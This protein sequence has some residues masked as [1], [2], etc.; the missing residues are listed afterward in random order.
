VV[1]SDRAKLLVVGASFLAA[2]VVSTLLIMK[3]RIADDENPIRVRNKILQFES[4][5]PNSEWSQDG[6]KWRLKKNKH[7]SD[8]FQVTAFGSPSPGCLNPLSG[9]N[10]QVDFRV[11]GSAET[12]TFTI[13][14]ESEAGSSGPN[15]KREPVVDVGN[16]SM[17]AENAGLKKRIQNPDSGHITQITVNSQAGTPTIC[18]FPDAPRVL[19]E[20][21]RGACS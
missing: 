10:V 6:T 15:P 14:T 4:E 13:S 19:I 1:M 9:I 11:D 2:G 3:V 16:V 7:T 17:T 8:L 20:L 12:R 21:C 5:G 18:T